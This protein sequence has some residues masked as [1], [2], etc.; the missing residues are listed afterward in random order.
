MKEHPATKLCKYCKTEIPYDA[1][2]CPNCKKRQTPSGCLI[3][4]IVVVAVCILIG[5]F[6]ASKGGASSSA[7]SAAGGSASTAA[8]VTEQAPTATYT[9]GDT[10]DK[11]GVKI[12]LVSAEKNSGTEFLKPADGNTFV[13][14]TFEI[15]NGS[16][17]DI[18]ISSIVCFEAYCDD[19]AVNQSLSGAAVNGASTLDGAVASGKKINGVISYE[20]PAD[21]SELEV[22]VKPDFWSG[23]ETTFVISNS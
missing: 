16:S 10:V 8:A 19:Y 18:N 1:K 21:F 4:V 14:L 6:G 3:A 5:A 2:I 15:E 23:D 13:D 7:S 17:S 20:V 22:T 12:T 9:V 11:N